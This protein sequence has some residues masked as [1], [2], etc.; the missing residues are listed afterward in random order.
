MA[1]CVEGFPA[2]EPMTLSGNVLSIYETSD[3]VLSCAALRERSTE[4]R[5]EELAI[6][7]GL[8]H[9]AFYRP[10]DAWLVP[11]T[12]WIARTNR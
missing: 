8:R 6:S 4:A 9:G 1:T 11:L 12:A 3:E 10:I 5:F 2:K 7:T